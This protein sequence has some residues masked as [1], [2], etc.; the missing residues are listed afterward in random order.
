MQALTFGSMRRRTIRAFGMN[1]LVRIS[2]RV[3]AIVVVSAIAISLLAAPVA[4]AIG[5]AVHDSRSR[6][7]AVEAHALRPVSA[8]VTTTRRGALAGRLSMNTN[9]VEAQWVWEGV[10][11][12][13]W[14]RPKAS[15]RVG[16]QI[17]IRVNSEGDRVEPPPRFQAVF[18]AVC[19]AVPFW[20]VVIGIAALLAAAVRRL[21]DH[22]HDI[23]WEREIG[24][25]VGSR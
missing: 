5:T 15:V 11:H 24:R 10:G 22:H 2:D 8:I 25:L 3:E 4:G 18:V 7:Y 14:F 9:I 17:D 12:T 19:V 16:D 13:E 6:I 1:P 20:A 21:I 23:A